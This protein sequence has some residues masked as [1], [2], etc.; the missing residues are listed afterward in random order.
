MNNGGQKIYKN[1][2]K[3]LK[4]V[5]L[6]FFLCYNNGNSKRMVPKKA[7]AILVG[8]F[9]HQIDEKGRIRVPARLRDAIGSSPMLMKGTDGCL[10]LYSSEEADK[11]FTRL[12][13]DVLPGDEKSEALRTISENSSPL[14]ADSQG[15]FLLDATLVKGASIKKNIVTI[16]AYNHLEIWAEEVWLAR[17]EKATMTI[18]ESFKRAA[19]KQ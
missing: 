18:E 6:L 7:L 13:S 16:G 2:Q 5:A 8:Q 10:L 3:G 11:L 12:F 4:M 1:V 19:G 14:E 15:R 17:K 9:N